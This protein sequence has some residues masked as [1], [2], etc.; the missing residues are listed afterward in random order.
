MKKIG[1]LFPGQGSQAVAMGQDAANASETAKDLFAVADEQLGF[2]LSKLCFEGPADD[3][4]KTENTQPALYVSSAATLAVLREAGIEP[5]AVAGHSLG[6]YTA[7][8]AAG[9][10]DFATGLRLVRTRGEAFAAAGSHRPGAMAAIMGLNVEALSRICA[11][12]SDAAQVVVPAN[13]NDP[14]QAVISGDPAAVAAACEAC[15]AAGAKRAIM[16]PVSG[17]FHSPLVAPA[18]ETMRAAL[19]DAKLTAPNCVFVNNVD[20][21]V[22]SDPA[23][24]RDSL[25]RQITG[26]VRWIDCVQKLVEAG[27]EE[28]IEVG[29]GKVLS[30]LVRRIA[31]E[32][33]CHTTENADAITR[34]IQAIKGEG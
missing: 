2:P 24:I 13:L 16:L 25:V 9:V 12:N 20:A 19:E 3:L 1:F 5:F 15:K 27:V 26:T 21:A 32:I 14:G 18:A 7:L 10:F 30:G 29:S 17:A 23:A 4:V 8:H 34:A 31:K 6:E 11:E 22:L 28:F 33:P